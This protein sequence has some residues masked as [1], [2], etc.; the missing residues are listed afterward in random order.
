MMFRNTA[1]LSFVLASLSLTHGQSQPASSESDPSPRRHN[2]YVILEGHTQRENFHSPLP[3][4]Y[5]KEE[6][7][8]VSRFQLLGYEVYS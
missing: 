6:D 8:P 7:L 4:T 1:F 5:I 2:E 3:H